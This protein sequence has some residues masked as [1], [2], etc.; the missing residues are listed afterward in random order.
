MAIRDRSGV[1]TTAAPSSRSIPFPGWGMAHRLQQRVRPVW[2]PK[3]PF[4]LDVGISSTRHIAHFWGI[5]RLGDGHAP[6]VETKDANQKPAVG[7]TRILLS[8]PESPA[9]AAQM[10]ARE[11]IAARH[12]STTTAA[13]NK[14][15]TDALRSAGLMR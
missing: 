8:P 7:D 15:I 6:A 1:V 9:W 12:A 11:K 3:S 13:I 10:A 5:A 2:V 14:V 4:M